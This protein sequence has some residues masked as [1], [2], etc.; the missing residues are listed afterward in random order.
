MDDQFV[1]VE[2]LWHGAKCEARI[3]IAGS[4][5]EAVI[6]VAKIWFLETGLKETSSGML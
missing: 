4:Q 5:I 3:R 6:G 2:R 1:R